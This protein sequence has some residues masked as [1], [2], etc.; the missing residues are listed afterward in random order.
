MFFPCDTTKPNAIQFAVSLI[1]SNMS[2]RQFT[3]ANN[4]SEPT[5]RKLGRILMDTEMKSKFYLVTN[6]LLDVLKPCRTMPISSEQRDHIDLSV[7]ANS[8][9]LSSDGYIVIVFVIWLK[10]CGTNQDKP[11]PKVEQQNEPYAHS[12]VW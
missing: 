6:M 4:L 8:S 11:H 12:Y 7:N 3:W 5:Y 1:G 2:W 9:N 10:R